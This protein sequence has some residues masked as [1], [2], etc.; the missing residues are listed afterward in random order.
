MKEFLLT[1]CVLFTIFKIF[2]GFNGSD[3]YLPDKYTDIPH[4]IYGNETEVRVTFYSY[5]G[6]K[7]E[8]NRL[9]WND[10][11]KWWYTYQE[12]T[13]L[14]EGVDSTWISMVPYYR[15]NDSY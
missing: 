13:D 14:I 9:H 8:D 3:I 1:V 6:L 7:K 5:W 12:R 15:F 10:V 11:E 4:P 2:S